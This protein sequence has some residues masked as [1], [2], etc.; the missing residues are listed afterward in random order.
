M[1]PTITIQPDP[2]W[3]WLASKPLL[4]F[5]V[6]KWMH[7]TNSASYEVELGASGLLNAPRYRWLNLRTC[8]G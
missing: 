5:E 1:V 7:H 2:G 4:A 8:A 3:C 6:M